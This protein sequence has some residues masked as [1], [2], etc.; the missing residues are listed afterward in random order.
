MLMLMQHQSQ[1]KQLLLPWKIPLL[2]QH[3]ESIF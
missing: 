1:Q 2:D 3:E